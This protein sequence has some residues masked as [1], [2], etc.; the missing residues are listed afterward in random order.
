M[1]EN[2]ED[3]DLVFRIIDSGIDIKI[4]R[5]RSTDYVTK[6][7]KFLANAYLFKALGKER[8]GYITSDSSFVAFDPPGKYMYIY[9]QSL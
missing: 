1:A 9:I 5:K 7:L 8:Q 3:I 6:Y 2:I 4:P